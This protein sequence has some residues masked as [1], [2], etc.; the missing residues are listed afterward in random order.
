MSIGILRVKLEKGKLSAPDA[1]ATASYLEEP[2]GDK[3]LGF[4]S[5]RRR[6]S[7]LPHF[8]TE[9]MVVAVIRWML[10]AGLQSPGIPVYSRNLCVSLNVSM[11]ALHYQLRRGLQ[12]LSDH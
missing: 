7:L 8:K 11:N 12:A 3:D 5:H 9:V 10:F 4:R 6:L 1:M 2:L